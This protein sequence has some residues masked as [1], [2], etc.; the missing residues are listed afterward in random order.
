[1][2]RSTKLL[3]VALSL[4]V[5]VFLGIALTVKSMLSG[6][7]KDRIIAA[8]S[9]QL[10]VSL[11]VGSIETSLPKVLTMTPA[12]SLGGIEI[13]NPPGFS[14][15]PMVVAQAIDTRVELGSLFSGTPRIIA[16]EILR[17]AV[18]I[19]K[20]AAGRTNL[21]VFLDGLSKE[22]A[23]AK[24]DA[25]Q[26][27]DAAALAIEDL[28]ISGGS[29][30]VA[31]EPLGAWGDI[32]VRLNGFGTPRPLKAV[33]FASM[34]GA[35]KARI[36]FAGGAGPFAGAA[37]PVD[38]KLKISAAPG[39]KTRLELDVALK[40]DLSTVA[41][42]PAR[43]VV[44]D[45]P[46]GTNGQ[47]ML[48]LS[49]QAE[50]TVTLKE[51]LG[52]GAAFD[53]AIPKATLTL[54]GGQLN[55]RIQ[56]SRKRNGVTGTMAGALGGLRIEQM[57]NAFS[58][59]NPGVE[60]GLT[61]PRFQLSFAGRSAGELAESLTGDGRLSI[62]QGKLPRMD[63]IG[64]ITG[65]IGK[66]GAMTTD[67]A[68]KFAELKTDFVVANQVVRLSNLQMEAAGL[69]VTGAGTVAMNK[70]LNLKL[71]TV[72]GGKVAE[73]LG[74]RGSGDQP[75]HANVPVDVTGTTENPKVMPN[76][77]SMAGEAA[78]NYLGGALDK[79]FGGRKK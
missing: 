19:E 73:L 25:A 60:G 6:T 7:G 61:M 59:A 26:K 57:L 71:N 1:M 69:K 9:G 37:M 75:A 27:S 64:A 68:T 79:F 44:T 8:L 63:L 76:A 58:A 4:I 51:A 41:E 2:S 3:I 16:L 78:K 62:D 77:K 39:E 23:G 31:G 38:G 40:G 72:V 18:S 66:T 46:V 30:Q 74:A 17:P 56:L 33:A 50:G 67:G 65:A 47:K 36:E 20:N 70:A 53:V 13:G 24:P 34:A 22:S 32:N 55:G 52:A 48:P 29:F 15:S 10:G 45:Y 49:G 43:L 14:T 5:V 54:A 21:Q 35:H 11:K 28:L 12:L 42:G